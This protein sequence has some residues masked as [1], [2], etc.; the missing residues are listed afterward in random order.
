M[1]DIFAGYTSAYGHYV[2]SETTDDRGK[3]KGTARTVREKVTP[4]LWSNH[5]TGVDGLGIIPINSDSMV[6][7][8]AI[9]IDDYQLEVTKILGKIIEF[10]LPLV[11]TYSKSRGL[12]L[13][14]FTCEWVPARLM[15]LKLREL[16]SF[17]GH[18]DSEIFPKQAEIIVERGDMGQWINMPYFGDERKMLNPES[19]KVAHIDNFIKY[20]STR[21][22]T[23][24]QLKDLKP[25]VPESLAGGPPCLQI[26]IK[27]GFPPGTRNTGLFNLAVYAKKVSPD[28]MPRMVEEYNKKWM[29]P[30]LTS[31]EVLGI[32]K[33]LNKKEYEYTCN[34]QP[35]KSVC[36]RPKCRGCQYGI[37]ASTGLPEFGTLTKLETEPPIWFLEVVNGGRL[38]LETEDLQTPLRFQKRCMDV[39]NVMPPILSRP[40]WSEII[41]KLLEDV[42]TIQVPKANTNRG[43]FEEHLEAFLLGK[44][45]GNRF[46]EL[47]IGKPI[48]HDGF[49]YFRIRDLMNYLQKAKFEMRMN[50]VCI[51]L[52]ELGATHDFKNIQNRGVNMW[53][54]P[55]IVRE[56]IKL[57]IRK[58]VSNDDAF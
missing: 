45:S 5:L 44:F 57:P 20:V 6:K 9:D 3:R 23:R 16:A 22:L 33:S 39:L 31:T 40:E 19:Y 25:E 24:D 58:V 28:E 53:K 8:G 17:L 29:D 26:L 56:E 4:E 2:V 14:L 54:L 35:I 38:E 34:Q 30:P 1:M 13:W 21:Q 18:G 55:E 42:T 27:Q 7:F 32:I 43:Q 10:K 46:E 49:H 15:Q 48:I 36:N 41:Q 52:R 37:G 47:L 50:R 51:E 11:P 12:H